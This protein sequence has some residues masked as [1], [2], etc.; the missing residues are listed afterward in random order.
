M[1]WPNMHVMCMHNGCC[2]FHSQCVLVIIHCEDKENFKRE[3]QD[4]HIRLK[5]PCPFHSLTYATECHVRAQQVFTPYLNEATLIGS[6]PL[7]IGSP[8]LG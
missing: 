4:Y 1:L 2:D 8:G 3:E 6:K 5:L 7:T